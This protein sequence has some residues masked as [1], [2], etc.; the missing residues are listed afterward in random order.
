ML[1]ELRII[2][3][4]QTYEGSHPATKPLLTEVQGPSKPLVIAPIPLG[5]SHGAN[6][7]L[8]GTSPLLA[9]EAPCAFPNV[10]PPLL[11]KNQERVRGDGKQDDESHQYYSLHLTQELHTRFT[12]PM[13][14]TSSAPFQSMRP[15][16]ER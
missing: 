9:V 10:W 5:P 2:T 14:A 1:L 16:T 3:C 4:K 6:G 11:H 7:H 15:K 8:A 12:Y 13:R